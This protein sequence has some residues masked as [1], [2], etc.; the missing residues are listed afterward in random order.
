MIEQAA[1]VIASFVQSAVQEAFKGFAQDRL[2]ERALERLYGELDAAIERQCSGGAEAE[3]VRDAAD[4]LTY[5]YTDPQV[6]TDDWR[7]ELTER[8]YREHPDIRRQRT[9]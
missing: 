9:A 4:K 2:D 1:G 6:L 3:A 8:F 7:A 5:A